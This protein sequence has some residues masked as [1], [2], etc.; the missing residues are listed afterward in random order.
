MAI[1]FSL[2]KR[3]AQRHNGFGW[4][5]AAES[6]TELERY[7]KERLSTAKNVLDAA[8]A[9]VQSVKDDAGLDGPDGTYAHAR[10]TRAVRDE[11]TALVEYS[12]VLR[13]YTDLM[14]HGKVPEE[15]RGG[16]AGSLP[17]ARMVR[18]LSIKGSTPFHFNSL[19][20]FMARAWD[21]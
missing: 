12:R 3:H 13:I 5:L 4:F 8:R 14:V 16:V 6:Q 9:N 15:R 17:T 10:Y 21:A 1:G 11:T 7:W 19:L 18:T 20:H 2:T